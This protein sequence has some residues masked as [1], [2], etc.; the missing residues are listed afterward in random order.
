MERQEILKQVN[1]VFIDVLDNEDIV[2]SDTTTA[3]DVEEW[4]S[5]TH[6]QLIVE[7]EKHFKIKF[8]S[9]EILTWKNV[10]EMITSIENKIK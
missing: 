6:V 4:D 7:V 2:L 9:Q 8:T 10:G 1:E 5:L 3:D